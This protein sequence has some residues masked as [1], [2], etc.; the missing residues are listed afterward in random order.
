M[1]YANNP[2]RHPEKQLVAL[3]ASIREFGFLLPVLIDEESMTTRMAVGASRL[4][5]L[6]SPQRLIADRQ[7]ATNL[8][9]WNG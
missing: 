7:L 5:P 6:I 3:E 4:R 8:G 2:R 9:L 1:R